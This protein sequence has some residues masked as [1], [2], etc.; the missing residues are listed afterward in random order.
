MAKNRA[1]KRPGR[2]A[3]GRVK[4]TVI[5]TA[6]TARRLEVYAASLGLDQ[7]DVVA[8]SLE[9]MLQG[10]GWFTRGQSLAQTPAAGPLPRLSATEDQAAA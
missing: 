8:R 10:F 4:K 2:S 1:A 6:E 7:S 9:P 5:L 3:P